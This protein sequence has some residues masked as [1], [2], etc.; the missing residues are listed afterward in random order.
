MGP[1]A[2]EVPYF[3]RPFRVR[4]IV[5][6]LIVL[7]STVVALGYVHLRSAFADCG[8]PF[9]LIIYSQDDGDLGVGPDGSLSTSPGPPVIQCEPPLHR[10]KPAKN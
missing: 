1:I 2:R 9:A 5:V 7:V 3:K 10:R 6:T 4:T 8:R